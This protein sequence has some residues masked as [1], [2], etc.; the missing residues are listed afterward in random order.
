MSDDDRERS[1]VDNA[2]DE[3]QVERGKRKEKLARRV[4]LADMRAVLE[5]PQGRRVLNRLI[6]ES[7]LHLVSIP[8]SGEGVWFNEGKRSMGGFIQQEAKAASKALYLTLIQE[9]LAT[10]LNNGS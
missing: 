8:T 9:A 3:E 2:A 4:E 1:L 6:A 7:G 5:M 10:E